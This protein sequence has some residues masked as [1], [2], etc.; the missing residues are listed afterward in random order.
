MRLLEWL[1]GLEN[2]RLERDAPLLLRWEGALE[3][4]ILLTFGA[5]ALAVIV[6]AYRAEAALKKSYRAYVLSTIRCAIVALVV[7][8]LCRPALVLQ[9]N[10]VENS[11]VA[12]LLD[13][14]LS[15]ASQDRVASEG[16]ADRTRLAMVRD[17]F[18]ENDAA[19]LRTVLENNA[20]QLYT[21][22][23]VA[24]PAMFAADTEALPGLI[25]GLQRARADGVSTDLARAIEQVVERGHGRR[26]AAVVLASDG[27]STQPTSL[28]DALQLAGGRQ[29]PVYP[30]RVGSPEPIRDVEVG[31]LRAQE[32][33]F[34]NDLL[35]IEAQIASR[36]LTQATALRVD[37][38]EDRTGVTLGQEEITLGPG[39]SAGTVELRT[40]P[41]ASGAMRYR[42]EVKALEGEANL[43]NNAEGVDVTVMEGGLRVLY[44]EGYPRYEYRYLK[45]ALLREP[46][47][48]L[49]A[50][51][52]DADTQFIQEGADRLRRFPDSPEELNTY[53]VLLFGDVDPRGGWLTTAQ[54]NM[55]LDFVGHEGGG[56][57][58]I[59]GERAAPHRYLG[60]PLEK[61]L[62]VVIDPT[63]VG[64]Y[65]AVLNS[66][67]RPRL[68]TDGR[69]SRLLRFTADREANVEL[70][71][72]RP[73][74]YW[75][76]RTLGPK[77]G[78]AVL[79]DHPSLRTVSG[80]MPVVV[81]GRYGAGKLFFQA[82][83]D[84]WRWRRHTGELLH[85]SYWIH[86]VRELMRDS[87]G[88]PDRR[89]V[90]RTDRRTY[91]YGAAVRAQ[92]ELLDPQLLTEH[93]ERI[94]IT[95]AER[96]DP[97]DDSA[98][99]RFD[100]LRIGPQSNVF[101][102][103]YVPPRPGGFVVEARTISLPPGGKP[104]SVLIRVDRPDVETRRP[105]ADHETLERIAATTGGQMLEPPSLI[106]GLSAIRN[107]SVQI[108]DD[109]VETLWDSKLV[110]LLF[111][112]MISIEW[113]FRKGFGLL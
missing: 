28:T 78:A 113:V 64:R 33:V 26:L 2:I 73:E 22:A 99:A 93:P 45:N 10:R 12:L 35:A 89:Y 34:T 25:D 61:L 77:P 41:A 108:P 100:A 56:F 95:L 83:D 5:L 68:T 72:T 43:E 6:S 31:P 17:V 18:L 42:V 88:A 96:G 86:V 90:L 19:A 60:T 58:V 16:H 51:L 49:S 71:E 103:T 27:R 40:K 105:E 92:V 39:D 37:L 75:V 104:A 106:E 70:M 1:L 98:V 44:V 82:T 81:T 3:P 91:P 53:D 48:E 59:A 74:L 23:G 24:E 84:T 52:L 30:L 107:R 63:F 7:G 109:V 69:R 14:S 57:G 15:M 67:F 55:I 87:R 29:I 11:H 62:P 50:V 85:D 112:L 13:T 94:E 54:T 110:W 32:A 111:V 66:G 76:A 36:G 46:T 79:L 102:G 4:W 20:I 101:E 8:V 38:V 21:F 47:L 80:P 9:R 65:D 97:E